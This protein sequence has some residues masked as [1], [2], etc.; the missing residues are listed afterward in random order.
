MEGT[1]MDIR[2]GDFDDAQVQALL[3]L[4]VEGMHASSPPG[5]CFV[6]DL[7]GLKVPE[8]TF[9]TAWDGRTVMGMG[10]IKDLGDNT[11]ELKSMRTHPDH[12]RKGVGEEILQQLVSLAKKRGY[13]RVSLE[14]GTSADFDAALALYRRNGFVSGPAFADYEATP[15]NQ[16][17]HRDL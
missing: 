4:H 6:L 9:L 7:S 10:A 8:I 16:F 2:P 12:L 3:R 11:G 17:L 14:T 13:R 5:T 15:H 1:T